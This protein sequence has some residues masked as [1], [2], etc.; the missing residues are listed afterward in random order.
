[1]IIGPHLLSAQA[2]KRTTKV[3]LCGPGVG[4]INYR[5]REFARETL[6][7]F[8]NVDVYYGEE[9]EQ[10]A[11]FKKKKNDLQT[12]ELEFAHAVDFTLLILESPGSIAEL[13]TFSM[14]PNIQGRLVILVPSQFYKDTSYIARGPLSLISKSFQS[15]VIYFDRTIDKELKTRILYPL[16]F[17]KYAHYK[18]GNSY[19]NHIE[20]AYR[21]K[22]YGPKGYEAFVSKIRQDYAA[23]VT[24]VGIAIL[25][26]PTFPE[27]I[28][29]TALSPSQ[30]S[31]AL[32]RLY[33]LNKIVKDS[34]N[35][36]RTLSDFNDVLFDGF[37]TTSISD[38]RAKFIAALDS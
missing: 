27:L 3:F 13:G 21:Q 32:H 33:Q 15:N 1:M 18:L 10:H 20:T 28:A 24:L 2:L 11:K 16:T 26:S 9:I 36:Y 38:S 30:T 4:G 23:A 12:L 25:G 34:N 19:I 7:A 8:P 35:R 17:Y 37:S 22:D 5:I 14:V 29:S 31:D 6:H